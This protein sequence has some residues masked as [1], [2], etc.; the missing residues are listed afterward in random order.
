MIPSFLHPMPESSVGM[1]SPERFTYPFNY[2][3]HPLCKAAA[4]QVK[5]YLG[6]FSPWETE[7]LSGK[8]FGVLVVSDQEGRRSFLAAYSGN[9]QG[10][11]DY[12]YFV[13][14]VYDLLDPKG[15]FHSE[16]QAISEI[17]HR[18]ELMSQDDPKVLLLKQERKVRSRQLQE[19]LFH[20]YRVH[21]ALKEEKDLMEVFDGIIPP[22]GSGE[23]CAPKLLETAYRLDLTPLCM[24]EF[25]M[26][27]SP[28]DELRVENHYYPACRHKCKPILG[29]MLQGLCLEDNPLLRRNR[30]M[31]EKMAVVYE[32]EAIIVI[33]KPSGM[34]SVPGKDDLPSVQEIVRSR[35]QDLQGPVI[36]H[37]LDMDTSGLMVLSRTQAAYKDLQKQFAQH[38]VRKHYVAL[39]DVRN[40]N[41]VPSEGVIRLRICPNPYD[42]P[43]QMVSE[44]YGKY[45]E[46]IYRLG[47]TLEGGLRRVDFYPTTGRTHQL[48]VHAAHPLGLNAPILGDNLYG[49]PSDRLYLQALEISFRHPL[50]GEETHFCLKEDF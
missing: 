14:P 36:V 39:L 49:E 4:E 1:P 40:M 12:A 6:D 30:E 45:S 43:H 23:C 29:F 22:G 9:I 27:A 35:Y 37:R 25:W 44:T 42:R 16:E 3:P 10:R 19:W 50:T 20:E 47:E 24:A 28:R 2:Q 31:A 15:H 5:R 34:L 13:P 18:L 7:R 32:D 21:N 38:E 48:R 8:M 11:N 26:G 17:N 46:T 33:N 41:A